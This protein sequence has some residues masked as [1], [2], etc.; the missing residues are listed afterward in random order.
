LA[1]RGRVIAAGFAGGGHADFALAE[2]RPDGR[3][4]RDFSGNGRLR[5][6]FGGYDQARDVAIDSQG[7]IVVAG[8][9]RSPTGAGGTVIARYLADGTLDASFGDGGT[10]RAEFGTKIAIDSRDR[11]LAAGG[12]DGEFGL[13]RYEPDGTLDSSFGDGGTVLTPFPW[14]AA[15]PTSIVIDS[16]ERIAVAGVTI[17]RSGPRYDWAL[18]RYLP[19]GALDR[20]FSGDGRAITDFRKSATLNSV[21]LDSRDRI[22]GVGGVHTGR[23][24]EFAVARYRRD[25]GLDPS[26]GP[27]GY[28]RTDFGRIEAGATPVAIDSRGRIVAAGG[29]FLLARYRSTGRLD[30]SFSGNGR[31]KTDA[32]HFDRSQDVA[33]DPRDRILAAGYGRFPHRGHYE[34]DFALARYV[35]YP[36]R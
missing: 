21:A 8:F 26:F 24:V 9:S 35:G 33:I 28:V 18:A 3:L 5:S 11:I 19:D 20:T 13:T 7:R 4:D 27:N 31:V 16:E 22:V 32:P 23:G 25:G 2:F 30:R 17:A 1:G 12:R 36:R 34:E 15:A 10:V 6:D 14:T 29:P